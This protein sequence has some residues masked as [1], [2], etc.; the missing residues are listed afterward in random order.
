MLAMRF[1]DRLDH[2]ALDALGRRARVWNRH[3]DDRI[4]HVREL[5][6]LQHRER[7]DAEH[8]QRDHRHGGDDRALDCGNRR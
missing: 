7:E 8:D 4:L 1:L 2:L 5:V 6:G 3:D